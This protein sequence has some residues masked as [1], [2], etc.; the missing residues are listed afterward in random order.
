MPCADKKLSARQACSRRMDGNESRHRGG[1]V[2]A[3]SIHLPA[4]SVAS[5]VVHSVDNCPRCKSEQAGWKR[6]LNQRGLE[7]YL[8]VSQMLGQVVAEV[9]SLFASESEIHQAVVLLI[10]V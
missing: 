5:D 2:Q 6:Q 3:N 10:D 9:E 8:G 1:I 7:I 4:T